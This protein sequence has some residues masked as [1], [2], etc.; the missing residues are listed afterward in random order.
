MHECHPVYSGLWRFSNLA[1]IH[2]AHCYFNHK[3]QQTNSGWN[4]GRKPIF[5]SKNQCAMSCI[6]FLSNLACSALNKM[7]N[8]VFWYIIIFSLSKQFSVNYPWWLWNT[9][10][11]TNLWY[12]FSCYEMHQPGIRNIRPGVS[13]SLTFFGKIQRQDK[14]TPKSSGRLGSLGNHSSSYT[15]CGQHWNMKGP[16]TQNISLQI[17]TYKILQN[18]KTN[19][20]SSASQ[21]L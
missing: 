3:G 20:I 4:W 10:V 14:N 7:S 8:S 16:Q 9:F 2:F 5:F 1:K 18:N 15:P 12:V 17:T 11:V 13:T 19:S 21:F 6:W